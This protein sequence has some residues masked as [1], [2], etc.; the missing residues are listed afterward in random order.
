MSRRRLELVVL[1]TLSIAVV[2]LVVWRVAGDGS[3]APPRAAAARPSSWAT[4][5]AASAIGGNASPPAATGAAPASGKPDATRPTKLAPVPK[6]ELE[7]LKQDR[8]SPVEAVRDPFRF[9]ARRAVPVSAVAGR[10]AGARPAVASPAA[11]PVVPDPTLPPPIPPPPPIL[12]KFI[13]IV[14]MPDK[15]VK[16]AVLSDSR[17][18]YFGREGEVIEGRYRITRIGAESIVLSYVDGTGQRVIQLSGS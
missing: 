10:G 2:A 5:D 16:L 4:S 7:A 9:N 1:S 17:G 11:T 13:G 14:Q 15:G 3:A 6:V 18:V 8:P 12:L